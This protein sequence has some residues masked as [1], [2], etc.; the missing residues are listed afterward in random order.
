MNNPHHHQ[1]GVDRRDGGS[2]S[3]RMVYPLPSWA[4]SVQSPSGAKKPSLSV[5]DRW[6]ATQDRPHAPLAALSKPLTTST[7]KSNHPTHLSS[8]AHRRS[9][10]PPGGVSSLTKRPSLIQQNDGGPLEYRNAHSSQD[11]TSQINASNALSDALDSDQMIEDFNNS[12]SNIQS[13]PRLV[14]RKSGPG[15][16]QNP[17][18]PMNKPMPTPERSNASS[19]ASALRMRS[20]HS[21]HNRNHVNDDDHSHSFYDLEGNEEGFSDSC[22]YSPTHTSSS[23][24]IDA[25]PSPLLDDMPI[26]SSS[27]ARFLSNKSS[28]LVPPASATYSMAGGGS[29]D[30]EDWFDTITNIFSQPHH[31]R[32]RKRR[33]RRPRSNS[34]GRSN[35][36]NTYSINRRSPTASRLRRVPTIGKDLRQ[37]EHTC[38]MSR[39]TYVVVQ[40]LVLGLFAGGVLLHA[41]RSV[42]KVQQELQDSH[43]EKTNILHQ[44]EWIEKR[45]KTHMAMVQ[46]QQLLQQQQGLLPPFPVEDEGGSNADKVNAEGED[47]V[48]ELEDAVES[49]Q[50]TL[51]ETAKWQLE[52][53]YFS[54]SKL[55]AVS[56]STSSGS[57]QVE[58]SL[59][60]SDKDAG[61]QTAIMGDSPLVIQVSHDLVPYISWMWLS[62]LQR[63]QWEKS[64]M[65]YHRDAN[66]LEIIPPL[67]KQ[68]HKQRAKLKSTRGDPTASFLQFFETSI[69][70]SD[71][72]IH[73]GLRRIILRKTPIADGAANPNLEEGA[74]N[75]GNK[76]KES[77]LDDDVAT[78]FEEDRLVL[79]VHF[80]AG[81]CGPTGLYH[82][83]NNHYNFNE[84]Q[85]DEDGDE[86]IIIEEVCFGTLANSFDS[87]DKLRRLFYEKEKELDAARKE[88]LTEKTAPEDASDLSRN[89]RED[90]DDASLKIQV[91]STRISVRKD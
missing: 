47:R 15:G 27:P 90:E 41:N 49:L 66:V 86:D 40:I 74:G 16:V 44:M 9:V 38:C 72:S 8:S 67:P 17:P 69:P 25:P 6:A 83:G 61:S 19:P 10:P 11:N 26:P 35:R 31:L 84:N 63:G 14:R 59:E 65:E 87:L 1:G 51:Q 5:G 39:T 52:Q 54:S 75:P 37:R 21:S 82:N 36:N 64:S 12:F 78:E 89:K 2:S 62:Q 22:H 23:M 53:T 77:E 68:D 32:I 24:L 4:G 18:A 81:T 43:V 88:R 80:N 48:R 85:Q 46:Q 73:V 50:L 70:P 30:E 33:R 7:G 20:S 34:R 55:S 56:T 57:L 29:D 45:A 3:G 76:I 79:A 91:A 13:R 28:L 60:G 42:A 71:E 58:L